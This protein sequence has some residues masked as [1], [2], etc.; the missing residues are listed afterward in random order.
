MVRRAGAQVLAVVLSVLLVY[1]PASGSPPELIGVAKVTGPAE[2]NGVPFPGESNVFSGD[3]V[4]TGQQSSLA[5]ISTPQEAI[6]LAPKSGARFLRDGSATV[7]A[8][9]QGTVQFRSA[10]RTR[11]ILE[12]YGVEIRTRG[13]SQAVAHVAVLNPQQAQVSALRG[14]LE[15]S[16]PQQFL[17]LHPGETAMVTAAAGEGQAPQGAGAAATTR[18]MP[19]LILL[20]V[21][22][23]ATGVG[24]WLALRGEK[25]SPTT[26]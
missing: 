13:D 24:L 10:G 18:S 5:L 2:I 7:I 15:V 1:L 11:A 12:R 3:R 9:E 20:L 14:L 25:I 8:L 19:V 22:G 26:P 6:Q 16:A 17:L 21:L 4:R 23:T